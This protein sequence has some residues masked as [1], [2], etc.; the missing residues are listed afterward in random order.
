MCPCSPEARHA[1]MVCKAEPTDHSVRFCSRW[2]SRVLTRSGDLARASGSLP[3]RQTCQRQGAAW[4]AHPAALGCPRPPAPP[5]GGITERN[6]HA[7]VPHPHSSTCCSRS[8][9]PWVAEEVRHR[10]RDRVRIPGSD[11]AVP[12]LHLFELP[13]PYRRP[14]LSHTYRGAETHPRI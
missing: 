7:T 2:R 11:P 1:C 14:L 10:A 12:R 8:W 5:A 9:K 6:R 3:W 4:G 13:A